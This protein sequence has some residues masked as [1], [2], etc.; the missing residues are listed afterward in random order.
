MPTIKYN[1]KTARRKAVMALPKPI[2]NELRMSVALCDYS[3]IKSGIGRT[4]TYQEK[5]LEDFYHGKKKHFSS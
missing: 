1:K 3:M 4:I 2:C 5:S